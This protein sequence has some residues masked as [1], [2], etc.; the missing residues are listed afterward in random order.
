MSSPEGRQLID[1]VGTGL[2]EEGV[3]P[4]RRALRFDGM[5]SL[6]RRIHDVFYLFAKTS[7]ILTKNCSLLTTFATLPEIDRT[8]SNELLDGI[9]VCNGIIDT[10]GECISREYLPAAWF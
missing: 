1:R 7:H 9:V 2:M 4:C 10:I 3:A 8:F 5:D 6:T